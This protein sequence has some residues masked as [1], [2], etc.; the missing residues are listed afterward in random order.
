M[1]C[2]TDVETPGLMKPSEGSILEVALVVTDDD[3]NETAHVD[4][5]VRP[6]ASAR[7]LVM[8]DYVV[9]MHTKNGLLR[10]VEE[11]G[12][13]RYEALPL[14]LKFV[15][16]A[17]RDVPPVPTRECANCGKSER[18]H[19][20]N[21]MINGRF[22]A[23]ACAGQENGL[24]EIKVFAPKTVPALTQTP[25]AG[26]T[27]SFDRSWLREHFPE[28]ERLFSHRS[29]DVSSLTELA[30]RW[31]PEVYKGRPGA[32]LSQ[33]DKPHRALADARESINTL[34]Y[35]RAAGFVGRRGE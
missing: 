21:V 5:V 29:I 17:F 14:L 18:E 35:Y 22:V 1:I 31:A 12:I 20:G 27:V 10:D 7:G 26:S 15:E 4:L 19:V 16:N 6:V 9:A 30:K 34:R 2:W 11:R 28:L 13:R 8:D 25:L 23:D 3:L 33:D 32:G 24:V